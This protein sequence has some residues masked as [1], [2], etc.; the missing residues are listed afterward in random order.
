MEELSYAVWLAD[1]YFLVDIAKLLN[2]LNDTLQ[3]QNA[4]VSQQYT[5]VQ[6]IWNKTATFPKTFV[7]NTPAPCTFQL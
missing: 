7:Q 4:V 6:A 5:H 1:L 3:G 2:G